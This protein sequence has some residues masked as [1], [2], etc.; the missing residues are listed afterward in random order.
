MPSKIMTLLSTTLLV[1]LSFTLGAG[2]ASL[3][4]IFTFNQPAMFIG[5]LS[6]GR[7]PGECRVL[8]RARFNS[9]PGFLPMVTPWE[10]YRFE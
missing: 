7:T 3:Y 10:H 2:T 6:E 9:E 4:F 8:L 5:C 1:L